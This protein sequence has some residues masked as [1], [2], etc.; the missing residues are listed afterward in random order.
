MKNRAMIFRPFRL[1]PPL[2]YGRVEENGNKVRIIDER[3]GWQAGRR[4]GEGVSAS[5]GNKNYL[6]GNLSTTPSYTNPT[7][8]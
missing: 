4:A 5:P 8:N 1:H 2:N 3:D 7:I 6:G